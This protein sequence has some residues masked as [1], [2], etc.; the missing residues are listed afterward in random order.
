MF[1]STP[2]LPLAFHPRSADGGKHAASALA[3]GSLATLDE[4]PPVRRLTAGEIHL[5][6]LKWRARGR[7]GDET[8]MRVA[9]ALEWVARRR[10][11]EKKPKSL[12]VLALRICARMGLNQAARTC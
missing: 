1:S 12:K 10:A 2:G 4:A 5:V 11:A 9:D 8:A 6:S 3:S 7:A